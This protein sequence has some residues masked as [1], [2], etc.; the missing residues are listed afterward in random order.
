MHANYPDY[1]D[2]PQSAV[3]RAYPARPKVALAFQG[4]LLNTARRPVTYTSGLFNPIQGFAVAILTFHDAVR[5]GPPRQGEV[6][7][8]IRRRESHGLHGLMEQVP[9]HRAF[10]EFVARPERAKDI[11]TRAHAMGRFPEAF[12]L[13]GEA[14]GGGEEE[15][16]HVLVLWGR[17][18]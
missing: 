11:R 1:P 15:M 9:A 12:V 3:P 13:R 14:I 5:Q 18:R 16:R 4:E 8:Q 6:L 2:V 17:T 7:I 10:L